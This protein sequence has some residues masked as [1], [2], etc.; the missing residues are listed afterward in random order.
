MI[1]QIPPEDTTIKSFN[2]NK[3]S[4]QVLFSK[5]DQDVEVARPV[6]YLHLP[7]L[8]MKMNIGY[9]PSLRGE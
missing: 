6:G 3:L 2:K 5:T 9:K 1:F 4:S 7:L 8:T